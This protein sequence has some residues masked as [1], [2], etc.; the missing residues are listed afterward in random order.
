MIIR[1]A[2]I[3]VNSGAPFTL[4]EQY[5]CVLNGVLFSASTA[6]PSKT[7]AATT[8][9]TT[10][11]TAST[12]TTTATTT[13]TTTTATTAAA[14]TT[15]ATTTPPPTTTTTLVSMKGYAA[16]RDDRIRA[17]AMEAPPVS[18]GMVMLLG[19]LR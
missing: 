19:L 14:T 7:E 10:T 6:V 17:V 1:D 16:A 4:L 13:T 15:T 5:R 8:T 18:L 2:I 3:K 11:T 9:A 12:A